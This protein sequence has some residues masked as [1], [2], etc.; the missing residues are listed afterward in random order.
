[1]P[2]KGQ[3][4]TIQFTAWNTSVNRGQTGDAAH[5]TLRATG[6]GVEFTPSASPTE[7]DSTGLPGL[8]SVALTGA[9]M[10][11]GSITLAGTSSTASVVIIPVTYLTDSPAATATL[12]GA[13]GSSLVTWTQFD[14]GGLVAL[15]NVE[16][17]VSSDAMGNLRSASEITGSLGTVQFRLDPGP[18]YFWRRR[19]DRIFAT[20]P[21][22][23]TVPP[24]SFTDSATSVVAPGFIGVPPVGYNA[25]PRISDLMDFLSDAPF[26]ETPSVQRLSGSVLAGIQLIENKCSRHFL[27]GKKIDN[28]DDLPATR[29]YDP[30]RLRTGPAYSSILDFGLNGDLARLDSVVFQVPGK[31]PETLIE[32]TD[33]RPMPQNDPARGKPYTYLE[34]ASRWRSPYPRS[35]WGSMSAWGSFFVTGLWGYATALPADVYQAMLSAASIHL[36]SS[37]FVSAG[38]PVGIKSW[39]G[40]GGVQT[41]FSDLLTARAV[42]WQANVDQVISTYERL[43]I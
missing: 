1:M 22:L 31:D 43:G 10:N 7:V 3:P 34:T 32:G 25:Y 29:I 37:T 28:T 26:R 11:Y 38:V 21:V 12:Y 30:P 8:Y 36:F 6:D 2:V 41:V 17:W 27:A 23:V 14:V 16:I 19:A 33:Y 5:L 20:N 4:F 24:T 39:T 15:P 9:E 13:D 42:A 40:L 35:F 18:V